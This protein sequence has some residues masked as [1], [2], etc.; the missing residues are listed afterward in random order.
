MFTICKAKKV[1]LHKNFKS[2][3]FDLALLELSQ[4]FEL[5]ANVAPVR[6]PSTGTVLNGNDCR[7]VGRGTELGGAYTYIY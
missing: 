4:P 2:G 1:W 7:L 6:L 5:N 3:G